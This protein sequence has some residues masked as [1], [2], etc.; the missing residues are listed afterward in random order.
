MSLPP[1]RVD[2]SS[3]GTQPEIIKLLL[4]SYV[5]D[6]F[7]LIIWQLTMKHKVRLQDSVSVKSLT[8]DVN[9]VYPASYRGTLV[10]INRLQ[11]KEEVINYNVFISVT[12]QTLSR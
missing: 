4:L 8:I 5:D 9:N 6:F 1:K 10:F 11:N 12:S 2:I 7:F 3:Y